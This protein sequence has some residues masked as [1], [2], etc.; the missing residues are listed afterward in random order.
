MLSSQ[1]AGWQPRL[2]IIANRTLK[3]VERCTG[4]RRILQLTLRRDREAASH[5]SRLL[6]FSVLTRVKVRVEILGGLHQ[7]F[8]WRFIY[9]IRGWRHRTLECR[10]LTLAFNTFLLLHS[11]S[12][13]WRLSSPL[14]DGAEVRRMRIFRL[15]LEIGP[16]PGLPQ[17]APTNFVESS[18]PFKLNLILSMALLP[19]IRLAC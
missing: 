12:L 2:P 7:A 17:I 13:R 6:L 9:P 11:V 16:R 1:D 14:H 19:P 5:S 4:V 10:V 3:F 8:L 15:L 18:K